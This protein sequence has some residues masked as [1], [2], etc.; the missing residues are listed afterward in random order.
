LPIDQDDYIPSQRR[1]GLIALAIA[2]GGLGSFLVWGFLGRLDDG[3]VAGGAIVAASSHTPISNL[4]GGTIRELLVKEG[5]VVKAGQVL[6]RLDPTV[7]E[8]QLS[9]YRSQY[10]TAL[11]EVDR[12]LAEQ[13]DKRTLEFSPELLAHKDD[14]LVRDAMR[15]QQRQFNVRW[16]DYDSQVAVNKS[17]INEASAARQANLGMAKGAR[18]HLKHAENVLSAYDTL[19]Q[20]QL[21]R[22]DMLYE[23]QASIADLHGSIV[24]YDQLAE[25]YGKT[26]ESY[27]AMIEQQYHDRQAAIALDLQ[28]V[29]AQ[30]AQLPDQM[31]VAE[32]ILTR[33][34]IRSPQDGRVVKQQFFTVGGV[35]Q[36]G[37]P[38]MDIVPAED[39][40]YAEVRVD[41]SD[42]ESAHPGN[43][44]EVH[45]F[46]YNGALVPN[47]DGVVTV[48]GAD[49]LTDP[50]TYT[51]Y[52]LARIRIS[53]KELAK[54]KRLAG[55][56]LYPGMPVQSILVKGERRAIDFFIQPI[57]D[58]WWQAFREK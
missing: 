55:V 53:G 9:Q 49:K 27:Q 15:E 58:T 30:A 51:D 11:A 20:K 2:L 4:E 44:A 45:L 24:Q 8:A 57:S 18:E 26:M 40:L 42:I 48:V 32:D 19:K 10:W 25:Q 6:L 46:A 1:N 47:L 39:D 33:K 7:A 31:H 3:A 14:P 54:W 22:L 35:V 17:H 41:P 56:E 43:R 36:P 28:T 34:T 23:V 50:I 38:I 16:K 13:Q 12:D 52:Y 37:A 21:M 29:R 5:D